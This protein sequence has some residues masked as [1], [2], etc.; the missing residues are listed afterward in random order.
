MDQKIKTI[1]WSCSHWLMLENAHLSI[2]RAGLTSTL[3]PTEQSIG[4]GLALTQGS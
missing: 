1:I 4:Q 3:V 2:Y